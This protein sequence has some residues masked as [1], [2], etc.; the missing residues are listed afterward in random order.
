M[1]IIILLSIV[2]LSM[3]LNFN[4]L[5]ATTYLSVIYLA[6]LKFKKEKKPRMDPVTG[7]PIK[8]LKWGDEGRLKIQKFI[9]LATNII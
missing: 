6:I 7:E 4:S 5:F 9:F 8:D 1:I 2:L 3:N